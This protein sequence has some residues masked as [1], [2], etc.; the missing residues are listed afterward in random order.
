MLATDRQ[1]SR[2]NP[3]AIGFCLMVFIGACEPE[4]TLSFQF[5]SDSLR[6]ATTELRGFVFEASASDLSCEDFDPAGKRHGD[7]VVRTGLKAN[8]QFS[9]ALSDVN[10]E[11]NALDSIRQLIVLEAWQNKLIDDKTESTLLGYSCRVFDFDEA[12]ASFLMTIE[13][14]QALGSTMKVRQSSPSFDAK[15]P[16]LL[17]DNVKS[18]SSM[19]VQLLD[20]LKQDVVGYPVRFEI[21]EGVAFFENGKTEIVVSSDDSGIAQVL[22]RAGRNASTAKQG[23]IKIEAS[24][25]GF[26]GGPIVF[27]ARVMRSFQTSLRSIPIDRSQA[28]LGQVL[29]TLRYYPNYHPFIAM[30]LDGNGKTDFVTASGIEEHKLFM[31]YRDDSGGMTIRSTSTQPGVVTALTSAQL[32]K[33]APRSLVVTSNMLSSIR[34]EPRLFSWHNSGKHPSEPGFEWTVTSTLM[35]WSAISITSYDLD[36]DGDDEV[37]MVRCL[38]P[39]AG[40]SCRGATLES[41]DNEVAI[42]LNDGSGQFSTIKRLQIPQKGGFREIVFADLDQDGSADVIASMADS[43][44]GFCGNRARADFG[45]EES[46]YQTSTLGQVAPL[47]VG[48]FDEDRYPDIALVG[49]YRQS[50]EYS[51]FRY[52][53]GC[54][55]CGAVALTSCGLSIGPPSVP[56]GGRSLYGF[57][58]DL[59]IVDLNGDGINDAV[60]LHRTET[61]LYTY[62]ADGKGGF[63]IGPR[64]ELP[65][66]RASEMTLYHEDGF[67]HVAMFDPDDH[68]ILIVRIEPY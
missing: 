68:R 6:S 26:E 17:S 42:T 15:T 55:N 29:T 32:K 5:E 9:S 57:Q 14:I 52:L 53:P 41:P 64:I 37:G 38:R 30:D 51:E 24:A 13:S 48:N 58:Q 35:E 3:T 61:A 12:R 44:V 63:A 67:A 62:F 40:R 66:T 43:I 7:A 27:N 33:N 45:F 19:D 8:H 60:N 28:D 47:A 46:F 1:P 54:Q 49:A 11:I 31:L 10:I 21:S 23:M 39:F 65:L 16:L 50:G 56:L 18:R 25:A 20:G 34:P 36:N 59:L 4:R 22:I 2:R